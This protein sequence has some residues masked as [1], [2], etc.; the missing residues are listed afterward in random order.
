MPLV[1]EGGD[2]LFIDTYLK[3]LGIYIHF[4][5]KKLGSTLVLDT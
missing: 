1:E 3:I 5:L 2:Q 4:V